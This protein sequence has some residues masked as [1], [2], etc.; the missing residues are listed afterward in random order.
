MKRKFP[1]TLFALPICSSTFTR[2]SN[3]R[4]L[5]TLVSSLLI[6]QVSAAVTSKPNILFVISDDQ[7]YPHASAYGSSLVK[8]PG[9]DLVAQNG[10]LF[11]NAFVTSP[12]SS[13]SRASILTGLY[14][15]QIE[16]AGTHASS[17]P[18][19]YE[20]FPDLLEEAGYYIGYTGKGWGPGNWKISGR[21]RNP[22]GPE[23]NK[24]RIRPPY[25][26]ISNINYSQNFKDF[27]H[28]REGKQPFY[29]WVGANEP[30]RPYEKDSWEK[31]DKRLVD[32]EVPPFLP[33]KPTTRKDLLDYGTEIEWYDSQLSQIIDILKEEG[34]FENTLII[35]MADNG[36]PF[37]LA[38]ATCFEYGIHVPLAICWA[39]GIKYGG[40]SDELI[41]SVDLFP[42]I[43]DAVGI[44]HKE[45]LAGNSILPYLK[46]QKNSTGR[47][48]IFAGRERHSSAR[49][50]NL[51]YPMRVLRTREFLY[52]RN[53]CP[54]RYPAG[55]PCYINKEGNLTPMYSAYFDIDQGPAWGFIVDE[56]DTPEIYPYFLK[57]VAKRPYE[58][59]YNISSDPGCLNNLVGDS[60]YMKEL[61]YL[62]NKMNDTLKKTKDARYLN[63]SDQDQNVWET[64]PRLNG[65]IRSF[66]KPVF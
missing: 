52:I 9:F 46:K 41:S 24:R 32:V 7:S 53:F 39:D 4:I 35:V 12:G 2:M 58:E 65:V 18:I 66:P 56:K 38:K 55:D 3:K 21:R 54:E 31:A 45:K 16:E 37:P 43:L 19:D 44:R 48:T 22:A 6:P 57:A 8:T 49:Y 47:T 5:S 42:T 28:D 36:M 14:P 30:H 11:N 59:L 13:P 15:W 10:W 51:G 33:D 62:R 34:E 61:D 1:K 26:G 20:C 27:L 60:E 17:F 29:F 64:Y 25:K 63:S 50:N 23:Y 40:V